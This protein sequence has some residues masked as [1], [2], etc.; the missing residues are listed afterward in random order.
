MIEI[1]IQIRIT[2]RYIDRVG[3]VRHRKKL[4]SRRLR[5]T[6]EIEET[7]IGVIIEL[8]VHHRLRRP[9]H[10]CI[11]IRLVSG[12]LVISICRIGRNSELC[13]ELFLLIAD[14]QAG[15]LGNGTIENPV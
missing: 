6:S 3:I 7:D 1:R 4:R 5:R 2:K 9:V 13:P 15:S 11:S 12:C 10:D 14:I 8:V